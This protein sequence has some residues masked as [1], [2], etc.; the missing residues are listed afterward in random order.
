ML[1][2]WELPVTRPTKDIHMLARTENDLDNIRCIVVDIC[3]TPVDDDGL[4]F[5]IESVATERIAKDALYSGVR[6]TFDGFLGNARVA[7][8]I[9]L[10][11]SDVVTPGPVDLVY[12]TILRQPAPHL[13]AYNR[14]TAIAE[15]LQAM[16]QLGELNS[17]MKDFFDVWLLATSHAF[18]GATLSAAITHTFVHRDIPLS[19]DAVCFTKAFG[20][21]PD[22]QMQWQ[23]FVRRS[24]LAEHAPELF[25]D[26][27]CPIM[28]FLMPMMTSQAGNLQWPPG[29]PWKR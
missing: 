19:R 23:A 2:A 25:A 12:P 4:V 10:S 16:V 20:N 13:K 8:Q 26:A 27:W 9:D 24:Q 3:S 11:F 28:Q 21:S 29:G 6:S 17:R 14:E 1:V 5:D 18:D 7:M 22:K 15:K